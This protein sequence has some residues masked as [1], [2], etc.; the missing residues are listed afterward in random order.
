L[1]DSGYGRQPTFLIAGTITIMAWQMA[2]L[3]MLPEG[4]VGIEAR[5]DG[6]NAYAD[7]IHVLEN[8]K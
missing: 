1:S 3:L 8:N 6:L 7:E 2:V 4:L 5:I